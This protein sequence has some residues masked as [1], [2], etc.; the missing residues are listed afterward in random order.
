MSFLGS[1]YASSVVTVCQWSCTYC[2][3]AY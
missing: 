3:N 1:L 2:H